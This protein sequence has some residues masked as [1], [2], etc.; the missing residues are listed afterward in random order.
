[1]ATGREMLELARRHIGE[2]Y[3]NVQVPKDNANWRGPWDCAEFMS[4]VVY[5]VAGF[6]YGCLNDNVRPAVADAYTGAWQHDSA[7][8]GQRVPAE[9]AAAT[10]GGVVLRFPPQPGTMGHI[11][12][13]DGR[14][15]TV[16]AKGHAFG[17][18]A[19]TVHGRRWDTGVLIPGVRYDERFAPGPIGSAGRVYFQ[20]APGMDPRVIG[21]I[22]QALLRAGVDP[23][24]VDGIYGPQTAIAVAAFQRMH[25][26]VVDGEVGV[27]TGR[28]L[29]LL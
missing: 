7:T 23:G 24:P 14:G 29:G 25:G 6:L 28:A 8:R 5:Q 20:G 21:Q 18:V 10:V 27:Q 16:E 15:G 13:C 1:M 17:V 2:R 11:A 9:V 3:E 4:W 26:L 12:F 19:D 22:Q